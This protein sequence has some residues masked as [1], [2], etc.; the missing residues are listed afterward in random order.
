MNQV[1]VNRDYQAMT[2]ETLIAKLD[3]VKETG[4]G[5]YVARCPAHDDRSPSLAVKDTGDGRILLHCFA[6]C[7][8]EDVLSAVGMTFS[9]IMPEKVGTE[10]S[11]RPQKWINAKDGLAT[12][13]HESLVVA[14][15]GADFI[16]RKSL[17]DETWDRL[18]TAVNRINS[19]RAEAAPLKFKKWHGP[20]QTASKEAA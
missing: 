12:L 11:Y 6:G 3:G 17:D 5:K 8:T 20:Q 4:H 14:I 10:H 9:D 2:A 1:E 19:A 7:E 16:K 15:I 18:A 13:D